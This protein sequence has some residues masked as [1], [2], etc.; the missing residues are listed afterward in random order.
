MRN[1]PEIGFLVED[2]DG[3]S[4]RFFGRRNYLGVNFAAQLR[5]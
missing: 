1:Q 3:D 2:F 5:D 4:H